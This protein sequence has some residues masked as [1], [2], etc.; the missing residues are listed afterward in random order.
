[1]AK[2]TRVEDIDS[3]FIISCILAMIAGIG[4]FQ[5]LQHLPDWLSKFLA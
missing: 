3:N 1:M 4:Y 2:K 5:L